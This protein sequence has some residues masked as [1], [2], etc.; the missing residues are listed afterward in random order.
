[1][2]GVDPVG[3]FNVTFPIHGHQCLELQQQ[4][5]SAEQPRVAAC[6]VVQR[7]KLH[8]GGMHGLMGD[9]TVKFIS[10]N[11]DRTTLTYLC[12]MG[13]GQSVGEF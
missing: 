1:M 9:G 2:P 8:T 7:S 3:A 13:D 10:Q 6:L 5:Q 12:R 11:I 4:Y